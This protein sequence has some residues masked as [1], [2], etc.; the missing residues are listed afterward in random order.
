MET[1]RLFKVFGL[2]V[3]ALAM[4]ITVNAQ[5]GQRKPT[6]Y[7]LATGGTI[8]GQGATEVAAGYKAGSITVDQLLSAVPEIKD[9]AN[10]QA[11]QVANI[12]SQ[13]MNDEVWLK[14]AKRINELFA[15]NNAD[16]I[17][18]THG[19]DTQEETAYFLNLTVKYNKPV[20][21]VG[22]MR[23]STAI[24]ADGPRNIYNAVATAVA[25]ESVGKGVMVVMDDKILGADDL[26]K[27][28]TLSVGTF[29]NPNYGELGIV[30]NGKPIYS[31][32]P[33]KR[34]TVNSE[35]DVTKLDKLPRVEII[36]SYSNATSLFVDAAVKA[37]VKGIVTAGVG[38]GNITT[39]MQ[40]ALEK[41]VKH[42][43]IAV[44]RSS[45]IM[46]GPTAQWD[47][48]D[49]DKLNFSASWFNNPYRS[50]VLLMLALTKT[51][52]YKEIQRMFS[53]Y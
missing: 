39:D 19:T 45:R 12:G 22:S 24:S 44:V 9:I 21:L 51:T 47:E 37:H 18:I 40:N 30:Y 10:I 27:T 36:L 34:H 35:F 6:V 48:V 11:E 53:E 32:Q 14:L 20:I 52:D 8:A 38:N 17:V 3:M 26:A 25:P 41:A 50:R 1:K 31:R 33:M 28:N 43:K 16:A 42:H 29:Q 13:D 23:P 4:S 49:D 46:T 7:V 2:F 15:A 5:S